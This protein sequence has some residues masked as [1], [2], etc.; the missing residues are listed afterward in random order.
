MTN[1]TCLDTLM[2]Q[3]HKRLQGA[4]EGRTRE[5]LAKIRQ[6]FGCNSIAQLPIATAMTILSGIYAARCNG[7]IKHVLTWIYATAYHFV[8]NT[9]ERERFNFAPCEAVR[10]TPAQFKCL[11]ACVFGPESRIMSRT[12]LH[13]AINLLC[14]AS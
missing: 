4:I 12:V 7:G 14:V 13:A 9:A 1:L 11:A 8:G 6:E 10:L 3:T 5:F 2:T